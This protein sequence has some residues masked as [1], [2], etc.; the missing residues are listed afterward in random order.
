MISNKTDLD[1]TILEICKIIGRPKFI[2]HYL[3]I[4]DWYEEFVVY[5]ITEKSVYNFLL[6]V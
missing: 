1:K 4:S 6:V 3:E 2:E 5:P